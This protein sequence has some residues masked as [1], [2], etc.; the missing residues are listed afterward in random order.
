MIRFK[1]IVVVGVGL[2]GGSF[3]LAAR[4]AGLCERLTGWDKSRSLDA[5]ISSGVI[6]AVESSFDEGRVCEADLIYLAA[7]IAG[8]LDFIGNRGHLVKPGAII[9]DA[10]S[11]KREI[12]RVARES[13]REDVHFVGGH[14]MAGSHNRGVEFAS[15]DLFQGAPYVLAVEESDRRSEAVRKIIETV[16]GIG[17][18]PV[19][20]TADRHDAVVAQVSHAPQIVSTALALA[21]ASHV[22]EE[23][24]AISGSGL[25]DMTRLARSRWEV[26]E[27]ICR[28]NRD[29]LA[30]AIDEVMKEIES[31]RDAIAKEQWAEAQSAFQKANEFAE[32]LNRQGADKS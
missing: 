1:H 6:D 22:G 2:I 32:N 10:G 24:L 3:A 19:M 5:A 16:F 4:R 18:Q 25:V 12:C 23:A 26:W 15:A 20:M 17:A 13:I 29:E 28:T 31:L 14:P 21:V 7:P 11:S 30:R 27:G 9:T 8:I